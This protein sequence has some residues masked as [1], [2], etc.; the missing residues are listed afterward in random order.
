MASRLANI[1]QPDNSYRYTHVVILTDMDCIRISGILYFRHEEKYVD[2]AINITPTKIIIAVAAAVLTIG[3]VFLYIILS[4]PQSLNVNTSGSTPSNT[5]NEL[6]A[7]QSVKVQDSIA[8]AEGVF[9]STGNVEE[10]AAAYDKYI[11][12]INEPAV[13]AA[14]SLSKGFLFLNAGQYNDALKVGT[15]LENSAP[16]HTSAML[17][18]EAYAR[19][20]DI[21]KATTFYALAIERAKKLGVSPPDAEAEAEASTKEGYSPP[22][23]ENNTTLRYQSRL[24]ELQNE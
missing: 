1:R 17:I 23:S 6:S 8:L 14:L 4:Q 16:S 11:S 21:A 2:M 15:D 18:A 19:L 7:E 24:L 5:T 10:A 13:T 9:S 22:V 20:G 3:G 12:Q